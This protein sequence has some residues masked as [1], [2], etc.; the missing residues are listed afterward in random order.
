MAA[1]Q[2]LKD[3]IY[4]DR[5]FYSHRLSNYSDSGMLISKTVSSSY[6]FF[7]T[8]YKI[9]I[10]DLQ[11]THLSMVQLIFLTLN[12]QSSTFASVLFFS[13]LHFRKNNFFRTPSSL[14]RLLLHDNYFL[15]ANIFLISY[16]LKIIYFLA[17]LLLRRSYFFR[18]HNYLKC[19]LFRNRHFCRTATFSKKEHL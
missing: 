16:F 8:Y 11:P 14:E 5:G 7:W 13:V 9:S 6:A 1:I 15:L 12:L 4:F 18:I 3:T 10:E 17:Q 19:A 2:I